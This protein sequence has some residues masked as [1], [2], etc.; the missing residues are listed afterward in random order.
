MVK[1]KVL[2]SD[3]GCESPNQNKANRKL[4]LFQGPRQETVGLL[5][6]TSNNNYH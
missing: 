3:T 2:K 1:I 6:P 5:T 4:E